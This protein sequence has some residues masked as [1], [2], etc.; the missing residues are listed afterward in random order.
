MIMSLIFEQTFNVIVAFSSLFV[1]R[2]THWINTFIQIGF[3]S[4]RSLKIWGYMLH[5]LVLKQCLHL[6]KILHTSDVID[7]AVFIV[8]NLIHFLRLLSFILDWPFK[9]E[10]SLLQIKAAFVS[11][12]CFMEQ[13]FI[14]I[15]R[16]ILSDVWIG[17]AR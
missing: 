13:S 10:N 4:F 15:E 6:S 7:I 11:Q 14:Q 5:V 3:N 12:T 8:M 1:W 17:R 9:R 16:W 2:L